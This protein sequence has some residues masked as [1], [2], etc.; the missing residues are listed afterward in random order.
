MNRLRQFFPGRDAS[1]KFVQW[2]FEWKTDG[3]TGTPRKYNIF[4]NVEGRTCIYSHTHQYTSVHISTY[5]YILVHI[6][7]YISTRQ[8][9]SV[10][11][12]T[13]QHILVQYISIPIS[14]HQYTSV[15]ISTYQCILIHI[16]APSVQ[17][18]ISYFF[19]QR[20]KGH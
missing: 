1:F 12:S 4:P 5:Q 9:T 13:R 14:A 10:H 8:Y 2:K 7:T 15:H 6:S 20:R 17:G 18:S 19:L 11:I 3:A 16:S